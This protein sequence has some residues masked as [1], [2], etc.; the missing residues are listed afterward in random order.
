MSGVKVAVKRLVAGIV[1]LAALTVA[2][3]V[4]TP[5]NAQAAIVNPKLA[6]VSLSADGKPVDSFVFNRT[7]YRL[8][9]KPAAVRVSGVPSGWTVAHATQTSQE[10]S[11]IDV[12]ASLDFQ[13]GSKF[14][15]DDLAQLQSIVG[16]NFKPAYYS[17]DDDTQTMS[18]MKEFSL[19][20]PAYPGLH[21]THKQLASLSFNRQELQATIQSM[22]DAG[23]ELGVR[24]YDAAG[25]EVSGI[26][27]ADQVDYVNLSISKGL[28]SNAHSLNFVFTTQKDISVLVSAQ[29]P[30]LSG[31]KSTWTLDPAAIGATF[32]NVTLQP[33]Q[34]A[35]N[36]T[37]ALPDVNNLVSPVTYTLAYS[38]LPASSASTSNTGQP[39]A[40]SAPAAP[41]KPDQQAAGAAPST[42]PDSR[43]AGAS[44]SAKAAADQD[45]AIST[46][47]SNSNPVVRVLA[48]T[49]S[50]T[51]ALVLITLVL[52]MA[53]AY[54]VAWSRNTADKD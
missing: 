50:S 48:K 9:A 22:R 35:Q 23:F 53:A 38:S 1:G 44:D 32:T 39:A 8:A 30:S 52:A 7:N 10:D 28:G 47:F 29:I 5:S 49:G 51:I 21:L 6:G 46:D 27:Q 54:M 40:A 15:S 36:L 33:Q 19:A 41:S 45:S 34:S 12:S 37:R 11:S 4:G 14:T 26:L 25:R 24:W 2:V 31:P 13:I 17:D 3:I 18:I 43:A 16:D 42:D 20:K